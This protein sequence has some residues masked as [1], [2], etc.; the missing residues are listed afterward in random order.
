MVVQPKKKSV[1]KVKKIPTVPSLLK[2]T[3]CVYDK[4]DQE[5]I[6]RVAAA[7]AAADDSSDSNRNGETTKGSKAVSVLVDQANMAIMKR[8]NWR[9][10]VMLYTTAHDHDPQVD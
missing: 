9:R 3:D 2:A 7:V 10:A 4:S 6:S 5:M 8:G 1:T